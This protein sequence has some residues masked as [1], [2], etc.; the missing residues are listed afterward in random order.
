M[1]FTTEQKSAIECRENKNILLSAAAGSGKTAVLV[2]RIIEKI[3]DEKRPFSVSEA[4]VLTFTEA[5]AAQMKRKIASAINA[6]LE[7]DPSNAHLRRQAVLIHFADI[8]TVHAF[9]NR[10]IKGNIHLSSLP[11]EYSLASETEASLLLNRAISEVLEKYSK[12]IDSLE[13][14]AEFLNAYGDSKGLNKLK[15]RL[16]NFHHF[17]KSLPYPYEWLL[18]SVKNLAPTD[19]TPF[20][21][22][23]DGEI[24]TYIND[25]KYLYDEIKDVVLSLPDG[26]KY[27]AFYL[28]EREAVSDMLSKLDRG[29]IKAAKEFKFSTKVKV[30]NI[31][32]YEEKTADNFRNLAKKT[33]ENAVDL[34]NSETPESRLLADRIYK[35]AKTLKNI[36]L[37]SDRVYKK[38]K[39]ERSLLDFSDLEHEALLLLSDKNHNPTPLAERLK[40]KYKE[41]LVD[42]YQDTNGI[43]DEIFA[44]LSNGGGNIFMVGDLKQSIYKFRNAVP[45]L[46]IDKKSLYKESPENGILMNL[47]KNFRSR[48]EVIETVNFIFS[49]IMTA[50]LGDTDYK[51]S[52]VLVK[53]ADYP[54]DSI[55]AFETEYT[56][57]SSPEGEKYSAEELVCEEA[58]TAADRIKE[59]VSS[60]FEVYDGAAK[61]EITFRDIVILMKNRKYMPFFEAALSK[62]GIPSRTDSESG[63]FTSAEVS[64][65]LSLLEIIDNP[66]RDISLVAVLRSRFFAFSPDELAGIRNINKS[67]FFFDALKLAAESGNQKAADFVSDLSELRNEAAGKSIYSLVLY[68]Y[69]RYNIIAAAGLLS[70]PALRRANLML[71][72]QMAADFE[73]SRGGGLFNFINYIETV[74]NDGRDFGAAKPSEGEDVVRIMTVH[75]S[76]GVEFPVV[77]LADTS[78]G[79]NFDGTQGDINY[80]SK[81]GLSLAATDTD[82]RIKYPSLS[83]ALFGLIKKREVRS[84]E[85]RLLYVALTRAK[86]KLIIL[87]SDSAKAKTK[88]LLFSKDKKPNRVM[89][90][91]SDSFA[92]W[93]FASF[94]THQ[95]ARCLREEFG[96]DEDIVRNADFSLKAEIVYPTERSDDELRLKET[97]ESKPLSAPEEETK[98]KK[99]ID[100]I[101]SF[102]GAES[103]NIPVKI[104]VS[105]FKRRYSEDDGTSH[106]LNIKKPSGFNNLSGL[107]AAEKGTLTHFVLQHLNEK[108]IFS[109]GD[110][111]AAVENL[112]CEGVISKAQASALD[113][114]AL[115]GFFESDLARRMRESTFVK[116]EYSFYSYIEAGEFLSAVKEDKRNEKILL[117][118]TIDC[119]F[120]DA[121]GKTVLVDYKTDRITDEEAPEK[122]K[123]YKIQ[124][125]LYD[126]ALKTIFGKCADERYIYFLNF[127]KAVKI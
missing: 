99:E 45:E 2:E 85:M 19:E 89:L 77:V 65:V 16:V 28:A 120:T 52:E 62:R 108:E 31:C 121:E 13:P 50:E 14:F 113:L 73:K 30:Q 5:A 63:F 104:S 56:L 38:F 7:K 64:L 24:K 29:D 97:P 109:Q 39:R 57:V 60:G 122:A 126:R 71:L 46:F 88:G 119:F 76:K 90:K 47:S 112:I 54:E 103:E 101:L 81:A 11:A 32:P 125:D 72:A 1:E 102:D 53:G 10:I 20:K 78:H 17:L 22:L 37:L 95:S 93:L 51:E 15:S 96:Y 40:E 91:Q 70:F 21:A 98:L 114:K 116:K 33:F 106:T 110:L 34:I 107:S 8:S 75:K 69:K 26:H 48:K 18:S 55:S 83:S 86:E 74:R 42:E 68:I 67:A 27:T 6:E 80:H 123:E 111:K 117:Q 61:R 84:E 25:I 66:Y 23:K 82:L 118:G 100:E 4:L 105:E 87:S 124:L 43:Q 36:M 59:L 41:I 79:F 3:K 49:G 58:E 12:R 127:N 35:R 115:S 9:L 44:L 92:T 94:L